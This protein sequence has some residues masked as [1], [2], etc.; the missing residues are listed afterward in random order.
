MPGDKHLIDVETL[1]VDVATGVTY[2]FKNVHERMVITNITIRD[3]FA[4]EIKFEV[5]H[6]RQANL[7]GGVVREGNN[8][9]DA[10]I[11]EQEK[12]MLAHD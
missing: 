9:L 4:P 8:Y 2:F 7:I 6:G 12:S 3:A 10:V 11:V 1:A 5:V